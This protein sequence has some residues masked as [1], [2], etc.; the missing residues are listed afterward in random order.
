MAEAAP[1]DPV[2]GTWVNENQQDPSITQIVVSRDGGRMM[3]HAW[4]SCHPVDCDWGEAEAEQWNGTSVANCNFGFKTTQIQIV[5]Q[6]DGR[7]LVVSHWKY[8]DDSG[9]IDRDQADAHLGQ[10]NPST[11]NETGPTVIVNDLSDAGIILI[12]PED[13][14]FDFEVSQIVPAQVAGVALALKPFVVIVANGSQRTIVAYSIVW[15]MTKKNGR[16]STI[17]LPFKYPDTLA[18]G[19]D[20]GAVS[21]N[22][23]ENGPVP[24]EGK[25]TRLH[26]NS[27]RF[28]VG[29]PVLS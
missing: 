17:I 18:G 27:N 20:S 16:K 21:F 5:P 24:S 3:V 22:N 25:T 6:L 28:V 19:A 15:R 14:K 10:R 13:P 1:R 26:G 11:Q 8:R 12:S 2:S 23:Q 29:R 4:G 9:P 7:I